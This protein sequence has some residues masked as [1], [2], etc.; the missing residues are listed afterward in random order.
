MKME[1]V[2]RV[3]ILDRATSF[4]LR[5]GMNPFSLFNYRKTVEQ[6]GHFNLGTATDLGERKR[7]F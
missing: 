1:S 4:S 7:Q 2:S 6:I 3:K 5:K